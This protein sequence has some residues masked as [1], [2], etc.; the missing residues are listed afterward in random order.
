MT[1]LT[2]RE[3]SSPVSTLAR[4]PSTR[5]A[6]LGETEP[7]R[8]SIYQTVRRILDEVEAAAPWRLLYYPPDDAATFRQM[9]TALI[10]VVSAIPS[11][12]ADLLDRLQ[13]EGWRDKS[14]LAETR[15]YFTGIHGMIERDLDRLDEKA[16]ALLQGSGEASL[17]RRQSLCELA[18]DLKGKYSSALMGATASIVSGGRWNG[19]EVEPILF[20]EKAEE[21]SRNAILVQR[22]DEIVGLIRRLSAEVPFVEL[23]RAWSEGRQVDLYALADLTV[24]RGQLGHLLQE[25]HRRALYSGDYHEIRRRE[26]RFSQVLNRL[27]AVHAEIWRRSGSRGGPEKAYRELI[28]L[29]EQVAAMVDVEILRQLVGD[30]VVRDTRSKIEASAS[31]GSAAASADHLVA[32]LADDDMKMFLELLRGAVSRRASLL[33]SKSE[34]DRRPLAPEPMEVREAPVELEAEA[35]ISAVV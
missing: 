29:L 3:Q 12:I 25:N 33:V 6:L 22:L 31:R 30:R 18:A 7:W 9:V 10:E 23:K 13:A 11:R 5:E 28:V 4:V 8:V 26:L 32:L 34:P 35:E 21:F 1:A 16:A 20:P 14:S 17:E 27:E 2:S 15:F 24:L 19:V